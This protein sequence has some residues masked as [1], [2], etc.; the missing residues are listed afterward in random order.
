MSILHIRRDYTMN[1]NTT[2]ILY[3]L[4]FV[5]IGFY[6]SFRVIKIRKVARNE[7]NFSYNLT[8]FS[9]M[10]LAT[11][12][13]EGFH[14]SKLDTDNI[15]LKETKDLLPLILVSNGSIVKENLRYINKD[16]SW[17]ISTLNRREI[18]EGQIE[19]AILDSSGRLQFKM[20]KD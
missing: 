6:I 20:K 12:E 17:L 2:F 3:F 16:Y 15:S 7:K 1:V 19:E 9:D 10:E 18:E 11:L 4:L 8:T 14:L 5:I 13:D